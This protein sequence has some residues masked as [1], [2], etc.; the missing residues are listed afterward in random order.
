MACSSM[1][2]SSVRN[3]GGFVRVM[4]M[5]TVRFGKKWWVSGDEEFGPY[6]PYDSRRE[7]EE[8]RKGIARTFRN[9][10]DHEFATSDKDQREK[11]DG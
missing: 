1:D 11:N 7:A 2:R 10:H 8:A 4:R 6:G 5:K 9:L 3:S